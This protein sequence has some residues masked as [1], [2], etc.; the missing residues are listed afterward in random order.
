M[1]L[2]VYPDTKST[3]RLVKYET[4]ATS[5]KVLAEVTDCWALV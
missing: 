5:A 3:P 1:I 2:L 4:P